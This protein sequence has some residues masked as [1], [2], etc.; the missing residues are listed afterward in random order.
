MVLLDNSLGMAR[1]KQGGG[2]A[3]VFQLGASLEPRGKGPKDSAPCQIPGRQGRVAMNTKGMMVHEEGGRGR[4]AV[5]YL[6]GGGGGFVRPCRVSSTCPW[7]TPVISAR[8]VP[9][10]STKPVVPTGAAG[11]KAAAWGAGGWQGVDTCRD[12][13]FFTS[14][15]ARRESIGRRL[16]EFDQINF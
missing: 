5:A 12:Q 14:D 9:Q 15:G 2:S 13:F 10:Q 11:R 16:R 4:G 8:R 7:Q 1:G 6:G 3:T